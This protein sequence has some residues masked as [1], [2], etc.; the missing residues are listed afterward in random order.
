MVDDD[1][2]AEQ[3]NNLREAVEAQ[4]AGLMKMLGI[5]A[6]QSVMLREILTACAAPEP[7]GP[8]P[9]VELLLKLNGAVEYQAAAIAR[10]EAAIVPAA[11]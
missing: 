6:Q 7:E 8:S 5:L 1:N 11:R 4:T 10:I 3:I 2:L 9:L